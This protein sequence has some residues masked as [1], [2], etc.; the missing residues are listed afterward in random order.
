M[1]QKII[2][3]LTKDVGLKILAIVFSFLLWLVVVNIDDPK[4][5]RT[6]TSVVT[7]TNEDVLTQ[8]G[9]LYEIK[10]GVNTVSFRVT[11]KRSIIE[12]LSPSDFSAVADMNNLE[13]SERVPVTIAAKSYVNYITISSRQNYLY[14]NLKDLTTERFLIDAQTFGELEPE[15]AVEEVTCSPTVITVTGPQDIVNKIESVV[16]SANITGVTG[17]FTENVIPKFYD[18]KGEVVDTSS[19]NMSVSTV[20]VSVSFVN[21]KAADI[22]VKTS[23][24]LSP[25]LTLGSIKTDPSSVMII[26]E[27]SALNEVSNI[28]IPET[29]IN[30][31]NLTGSFT[32]SVDI[33]AYLPEGVQLAEGTSSKVSIYVTM[34]NETASTVT[35][36]AD[37][38]ELRNVPEGLAVS[39]DVEKITT[40]VFGSEEALAGLK[41]DNV[42]GYIDC[43]NLSVGEGQ[44]AAL[45]FDNLEGITVQNTSVTVTVIEAKKE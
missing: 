19:L 37:N 13:N 21:T 45:Q 41:A 38:I 22:V 30:L 4:Q 31:S 14:V 25:E 17:N 43:S 39:L 2:N 12:K 9:K 11:A 3:A 7:V 15:L 23:G 32:T 27:P 24:I 33:S 35:V 40:D 8:A 34:A 36:P 26:G 29:V 28:T 20:S 16:A 5:T 42:K 1:Q 10:D 18:A 44:N 6:F